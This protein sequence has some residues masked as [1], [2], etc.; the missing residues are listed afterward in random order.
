M[1]KVKTAKRIRKSTQNTDNNYVFPIALERKLENATAGLRPFFLKAL[2]NISNGN[3]LTIADYILT[4]KTETNLS[5]NYRK[6][7]I[8]VLCKLSKFVNNKP[9]KTT[10]RDSIIAFLN[11]FRKSESIDPLHKWIGTYNTYR[12][13]FM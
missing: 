2:R 8:I 4:M 12:I 6:E 5:G 11:N 7:T 13:Y 10:K 3:A 1:I 9:F